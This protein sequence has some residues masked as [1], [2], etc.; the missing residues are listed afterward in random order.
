MPTL[1]DIMRTEVIDVAPEDTLGEVAERMSAVNV[2]AVIVKDYGRLIGIL[3]ER[4]ML[5]AMAAR[6]H[7]SD[8]RVREWMTEDPLTASADMDLE[9]AG[10][11]MLEHNFRHLPVT[12]ESG[13]VIGLVSLRRLV[14]ATKAAPHQAA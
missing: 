13:V 2:G 9:D 7:T 6:V 1:A 10:Q 8:A 5:K 4:D 3:T 11:V 12:D 14:A